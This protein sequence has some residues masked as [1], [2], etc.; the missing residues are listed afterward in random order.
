MNKTSKI[1]DYGVLGFFI[2]L[3]LFILFKLIYNIYGLNFI[4]GDRYGKY[5][6]MGFFLSVFGTSILTFYL[7]STSIGLLKNKRYGNI[8]GLSS[9][10]SLLIYCVSIFI[11]DL[12]RDALITTTDSIIF[13]GIVLLC[14]FIIYRLKI[15]YEL[16]SKW[17]SKDIGITILLTGLLTT[18]FWI[19]LWNNTTHNKV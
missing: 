18:V 5:H 1:A 19:G 13:T 2:L 3:T 7:L 11:Y 4:W 14:I 8:F 6:V 17:N 15:N 12:I 9:I 16:K 10:I